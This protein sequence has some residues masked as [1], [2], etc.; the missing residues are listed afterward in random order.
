[1]NIKEAKEE[2]ERTI[3]AY[4][5]KD[6]SGVYRIPV[7]KQRPVFLVGAPGIPFISKKNYDGTEYSVTE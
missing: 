4:L 3:K 5:A 1:M 7:E 6:E 2:I